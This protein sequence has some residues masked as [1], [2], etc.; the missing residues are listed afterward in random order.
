MHIVTKMAQIN[1]LVKKKWDTFEK[2][3]DLPQEVSA[4]YEDSI[5]TVK[6]P[7]GEIS[8]K[9]RYPF[10]Y[11]KV[12]GS[13]IIIGTNHFSQKEKKII[14]TYEAHANNLVKGVTEGF[15]YKLAI[16]YAKFPM[17]VGLSGSKFEVKNLLGEKVPRTFEIPS[18][19]K[20]EIK[21]KEIVVSGI[22]KEKTGQ[23]AARIEQLTK[24]TH[25]DRRVVQDGIFITKKPH[26]S[27]V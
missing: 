15:E 3:V 4:V 7:K 16:V 26:K 23:V 18:D 21:G 24:I 20:V 27:Y 11:I 12:D 22:D 1:K 17:T 9:M 10:V 13:K 14:S 25:L 19:V 8:K 2:H 6:G 5:L